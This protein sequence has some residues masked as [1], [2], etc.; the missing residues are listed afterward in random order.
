MLD[1][2]EALSRLSKERQSTLER[3]SAGTAPYLKKE[4]ETVQKYAYG[5]TR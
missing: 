3:D 1:C 2:R 5:P 4:S